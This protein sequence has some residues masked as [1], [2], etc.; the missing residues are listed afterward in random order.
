MNGRAL[1]GAL[2]DLIGVRF[3]IA[4]AFFLLAFG[5]CAPHNAHA[6]TKT[7][8]GGGAAG[9][10]TDVLNWNLNAYP[11]G[12][13]DLIFDNSGQA[14]LE[15]IFQ[16]SSAT[17][18]GATINLN[19]QN[20][21]LG[22]ANSASSFTM[23]LTAGNISVLSTSG[24]GT[25]IIG[26]TSGTNIG[27][28]I[29]TLA[30]TNTGFTFNNARTNG[31]LLQ[32]NA[33]V[34]GSA[35]TV[36][37]T[38]AG[39]V[40]LTG[41]NTYSGGTTIDGGTLIANNAASLGATSGML[42][43]NAG[44]LEISTGFTST[45]NITLGNIASTLQIDPSQIYTHTGV[46]SGSGTLNKTGT[47]TLTLSGINTYTGATNISAGTL[48][49]SASDRITNTSDLFVSG[50]TFGLQTFNDTVRNV[51][52]SSGSITGTGTLTGTSYAVQSGTAS[53]ILAGNGA[54][55]TKTT[56][57]TVTLTG[58]NTF[59]GATTVS[60]GTLTLASGSGSALGSTSGITVNSGG[61]LLLG[62]NNQ[63]NNTAPITLS[64]GTLAKGNFSEGSTSAAGLGALTLSATASRLDFGTG[65]AGTL[66]FA[67]FT[68][69]AFTLTI[70]NWSSGTTD[71]LVFAS[72]QSANLSSFNFTDYAPGAI[73]FDLGGGYYE[74]TPN[75][76]VPEPATYLAG[77]LALATLGCRQLR[78]FRRRRS[79]G[80]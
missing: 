37:K 3:S 18:N 63:I 76:A 73:Q 41:V 54:T 50:G 60:G 5:L 29:L 42:T 6:A 57:G 16:N 75:A 74:I 49:I 77:A 53:P 72:N 8:D 56:A 34:S 7:W 36:T 32:I 23:T 69:G 68:P 17:V 55:M 11:T 67:S 9:D 4:F 19:N 64:G 61:T 35:K 80:A 52:L 48:Q 15:N 22:A 62:A 2:T 70:D 59:T 79:A 66:T 31:G 24:T 58:A 71:R 28:G 30:T 27:T 12:A 47:G 25:Y 45:R 13:D 78:R 14:T 33:V 21:S 20:W 44:T 10:A 38:G 40:S 65:T 51:T 43:L 1:F 39:T 26:A 46:I